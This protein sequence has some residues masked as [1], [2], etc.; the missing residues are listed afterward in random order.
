MRHLH[1]GAF[2]A[3][4]VRRAGAGAPECECEM[5]KVPKGTPA[6]SIA[7]AQLARPSATGCQQREV[8]PLRG[9]ESRPRARCSQERPALGSPHSR[10]PASPLLRNHLASLLSPLRPSPTALH[11]VHTY[12]TST[13]GTRQFDRVYSNYRISPYLYLSVALCLSSGSPRF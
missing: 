9:P 7:W 4:E 13:A 1:V 5:S 8:P 11:T 3:I 12:G 6:A 2:H 10:V